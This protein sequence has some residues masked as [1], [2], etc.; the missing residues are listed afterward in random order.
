M[1]SSNSASGSYQARWFNHF[2]RLG[3]SK[4][5]PLFRV[6]SYL[7]A[8]RW[9]LGWVFCLV[10]AEKTASVSIALLLKLIVD[11]LDTGQ[12]AA[13]LGLFALVLGYG[14][15]RLAAPTLAELRDVYFSKASENISRE[16]GRKI[17]SH[18]L[19]LDTAYYSSHSLGALCRDLDRGIAGVSFLLRY[20]I[21]TA[22]PTLVEIALILAVMLVMLSPIYA[23]V[24]AIGVIFYLGFSVYSNEWRARFVQRVNQRNSR[25][26][27]LAMDS[28]LNIEAIKLSNLESTT[29]EQ[30]GREMRHWVSA[31]LADRRSLAWVVFGQ[32][33]VISSTAVAVI[34]LAV[35]DHQAGHL[36][37]GSFVMLTAF[38]AQLFAPLNFLGFVYREMRQAL[39][40][41]DQAF[42]VL[43]VVPTIIEKPNAL[44]LQSK[45]DS[46]EL[47][48]VWFGYDSRD[49]VLKEVSFIASTGT[50]MAIVGPSGGGKSSIVRLL[51]RL[52]DADRGRVLVD[53]KDVKDLE[54]ASL[55][56]R[57]SVVSQSTTLFSTTIAEN[58]TCGAPQSTGGQLQRVVEEV[59]LS[60]FVASLPQGLDTPVGER[61]AQLSG[62][63]AQRIGIARALYRNPDV[64]I[65]DE[66]TAA[67][68]YHTEAEILAV[69][70]KLKQNI[71]C[72]MVA[73][74]LSTVV[75]AD[76]V[77]VIDGGRI[78]E[79]G[80]HSQLLR[81]GGLYSRL[82]R[83]QS[84][85]QICQ[86]DL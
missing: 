48:S 44:T 5:K 1:Q 64:L 19:R 11:T 50:R 27:A 40:D 41:V 68:D 74:R 55:R 66:A 62:G 12:N 78:S 7:G 21:F 42:T 56:E 69:L 57:I 43:N 54:M 9:L 2:V 38:I 33:L 30:Y 23:V 82:W 37:M 70:D 32:A 80:N 83:S 28:L 67:L 61:G 59:G 49:P 3:F 18:C 65:L 72:I 45:I 26:N 84:P 75:N 73:H 76:H 4:S 14:A 52:Y 63:Q 34:Y 25:I 24:S 81:N 6:V 60:A 16:I 79:S 20:L 36:S 47:D 53:G 15:V 86:I 31:R 29:N 17:F 35:R 51:T 8:Y 10:I 13:A 71:V 85:A 46:I 39:A 58:I 77:L 22:G